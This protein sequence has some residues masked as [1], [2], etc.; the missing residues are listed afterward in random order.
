MNHEVLVTDQQVINLL[1]LEDD[2][3]DYQTVTRQLNNGPTKFEIFHARTLEHACAHLK[4]QR[5]DVIIADLHLP[6]STGAETI[7]CLAEQCPQTVLLVMTSLDDEDV[8]HEA[9][10]RGAHGYFVKN[11]IQG[12]VILRAIQHSLRRERYVR[13]HRTLVDHLRLQQKNLESFSQQLKEENKLL[14]HAY[15]LRFQAKA[16]D[17]NHLSNHLTKDAIAILAVE[18]EQ[19]SRAKSE[20]LSTVCHELRTTMEGVLSIHDHLIQTPLN[21]QQ[22]AFIDAS[23]ANSTVLYQM[24]GELSDIARI[25]SGRAEL[26]PFLCDL[27][28]VIQ[29]VGSTAFPLLNSKQISLKW[30]FDKQFSESVVCD[31]KVIRQI[32]ILLLSNAIKFTSQGRIDLQGTTL[33]QNQD[34]SHIRISV[35]DT[36]VGIP[37]QTLDELKAAFSQGSL[38][39]MPPLLG[40]TLG[41]SLALQMTRQLGGEMGVESERWQGTTFWVDIP[42]RYP[43]G[44]INGRIDSGNVPRL[45]G[46]NFLKRTSNNEKQSTPKASGHHILVAHENRA[47]QLYIV[48]QLRQLGHSAETA[49]DGNDVMYLLNRKDF[50]L[51]MLDCHLPIH[52]AFVIADGI[53]GLIP[54]GD[55][56]PKPPK[57]IAI[58]DRLMID[59][60]DKD[61]VEN[62][63]AFLTVPLEVSRLRETIRQCL[64]ENE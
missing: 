46:P 40:P 2:D 18:A 12:K 17:Y 25:E 27:S 58:S 16:T 21:H 54:N 50:D 47:L 14:K 55:H 61:Q 41:L 26:Q 30:S 51:L 28:A 7:A 11:E 13:Q 63:D 62:I 42:V 22:K 39:S 44:E 9:L 60:M 33:S 6:D 19:A 34:G 59:N 32:L 4:E 43:D 35:T 38:H 29:E 53:E 23:L 56:Q 15:Q 52:D 31:G 36:G 1:L 8:A 3:V 10:N 24:L 48:E 45:K 5:Y 64:P 57:I 20:F 49:K 37:P